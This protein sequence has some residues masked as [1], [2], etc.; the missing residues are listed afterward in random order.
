V[1][2]LRA[3]P[4]PRRWSCPG[5][6]ACLK[7]LMQASEGGWRTATWPRPCTQCWR[8]PW[9][10][11]SDRARSSPTPHGNR[12]VPRPVHPPVS[13]VV[14][15]LKCVAKYG[16]ERKRIDTRGVHE[17]GVS[18][19]LAEIGRRGGSARLT[20][21]LLAISASSDWSDLADSVLARVTAKT[22][23]DWQTSVTYG[24][25]SAGGDV[26]SKERYWIF[27][28]LGADPAE[29]YVA[30]AIWVRNE[31]T[32]RNQEFLLRNG[33]KRPVNPDSVHHKIK[34]KWI[35]QWR[36]RWGLLGLSDG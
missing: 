7:T 5:S 10:L 15:L 32:K 36:H 3:A 26:A 33:G 19:A 35:E 24:R 9:K 22:S 6:G 12:V 13:S 29:F 4:P 20:G 18:T 23:G 34:A 27:V 16:M 11:S 28:D 14:A 1:N 17:A 25:G 2:L 8:P 31:I 21:R 30:P